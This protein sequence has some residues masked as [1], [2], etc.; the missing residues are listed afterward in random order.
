MPPPLEVTFW[1]VGQGDCST[2]RLP[3]GK[4][5]IIDV[6]PRGSPLI[7]WLQ[8][9]PK[10]IYAVVLTHNDSDHVGALP[11]L[12]TSF[13]HQIENFFM[14]V[15]RPTNNKVFDKTFRCALEGE[16]QG[17]YQIRRL[18]VGTSVW[19]DDAL[20]GQLIP[21]FPTMSGNV[22]ATTPNRTSAV[23]SLQL[24]GKTEII[25]PGD[26]TLGRV[27][28]VCSGTSP[29]VLFGPHHGAPEDYHEQV[30][31]TSLAAI[32]ARRAFISVGTKNGYSHPRP[33]YLQ[34]LERK[35]SVVGFS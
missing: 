27:A 13:K 14:L 6:G 11:A 23:L 12:I 25:W 15:D 18:E 34:R 4:I 21:V 10:K 35:S 16:T 29:H 7:D 19:K 30:A 3:D 33:K 24:N 28:S 2:I 22:Q 26:S 5:I 32:N 20:S 31:V 17:H 9:K 8:D 1:D